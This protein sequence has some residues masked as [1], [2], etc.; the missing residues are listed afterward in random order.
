M[1]WLRLLLA[2][3]LSRFRSK[4][5]INETS[6][7]SFRVWLTDIDASIMNHASMMTVFEAGRIDFMVRTGF[8][9]IARQKKW[10]FPSASIHVQFFR[11]LRLFQ[12]AVLTTRILHLADHYVFT[13]Q[14]ITRNG[15]DIAICI[16][17]SKVKS[18]KNNIST[19]EIIELLHTG[20]HDLQ[21]PDLVNI[22]ENHENAFRNQVCRQEDDARVLIK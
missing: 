15:K 20:D 19:R 18:G 10:Y 12:K 17:K 22:Y 11:P 6:E 2:L 13:E 7:L 16:V 1:R 8:F 21:S 14:K 3:L 9:K 4:L 5:S